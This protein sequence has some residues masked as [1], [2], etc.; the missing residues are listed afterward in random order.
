MPPLTTQARYQIEHD[1]RLG[2][3][4]K[5]IA[6]AL[7]K[8]VRTIERERQRCEGDDEYTAVVLKARTLQFC[9]CCGG[10]CQRNTH[11]RIP[12]MCANVF[13]P[14]RPHLQN[15]YFQLWGQPNPST[16][17]AFGAVSPM[18]PLKN[19]RERCEGHFRR[20]LSP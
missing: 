16:G 17:A 7:G 9:Q 1:L 18:S 5:A 2:L 4:N 10:F 14:Q 11:A 20:R 15:T 3:D 6:K 13:C 12:A 19:F 8:C